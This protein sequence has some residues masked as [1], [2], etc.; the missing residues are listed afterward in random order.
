MKC[1]FMSEKVNTDYEKMRETQKSTY[2]FI[3]AYQT[4]ILSDYHK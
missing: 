3:Y 2:Q 4:L 1:V